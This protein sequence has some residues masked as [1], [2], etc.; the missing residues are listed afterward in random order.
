MSFIRLNK[1]ILWAFF[2]FLFF[3][4]LSVLNTPP[5]FATNPLTDPANEDG[6]DATDADHPER[7]EARQ[8]FPVKL[9]RPPP[10]PRLS[11]L[12]QEVRVQRQEP[13][14]Q[15]VQLPH[16]PEKKKSRNTKKNLYVYIHTCII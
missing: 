7:Y 1:T 13:R 8:P 6:T 2:L 9:V 16:V 15:A 10:E 12:L 3:C 4:I 5:H 14:P 11:F